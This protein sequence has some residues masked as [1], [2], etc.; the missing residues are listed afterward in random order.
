MS[1]SYDVIVLGSGPGGY[2]S[3]I[4]AAQ[5]GLKVAIVERENLGGICLNWGCIP[6]KALLRSAEV[7][8]HA[9]HFKDYGL[10]LE[11]T[12]TPDVK[13]VVAR[14]RGVSSRLTGG[15]AFL[16][17]KNKIDVIWGEAKI[18]KPGEIEIRKL[19][20]S[21]FVG[22]VQLGIFTIVGLAVALAVTRWVLPTLTFHEAIPGHHMQIAIA[23]ETKLPLIRKAMG[24]SAYQEGWALYAEQVA[25]EI[26]MYD[27]DP[28]G[29]I[30]Q[31]HDSM[32]RGVR[33]VVDSGM[34]GLKWSREKAL[35]Y[36]TDTLGDPE[37]PEATGKVR[38]GNRTTAYE[39]ED[40][41][42]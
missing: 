1:E 26:G 25:D 8:D 13:A 38:L 4:R 21:S 19:L 5:L 34:H 20:F 27:N 41:E 31:L 16:M 30:G 2:V 22:F 29:R 11:G 37:L 17:K 6:T 42:G 3:A 14:S 15:V 28:F 39:A 40:A 12:V 35:T 33:L 9:N 32:F 24:F 18:T 10:V 23:N 36:F 7:M